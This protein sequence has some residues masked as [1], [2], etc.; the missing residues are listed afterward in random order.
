MKKIRKIDGSCAPLALK[1]LSKKSDKTVYDVCLINW[2]QQSHGMEEHEFLNAAKA[3]GIRLRRIKLKKIGLYRSKLSKFIKNNPKGTYL[4]YTHAHIF[5]I[6]NGLV[7]DKLNPKYLG[8]SR[9]VTGA[10]KCG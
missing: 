10:W 6:D 4:I 8:M 3:L 7:I 2:F 9:M 5:V 1:Y